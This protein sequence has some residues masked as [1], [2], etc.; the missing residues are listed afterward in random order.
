MLLLAKP[1]LPQRDLDVAADLAENGSDAA[2]KGNR[3]LGA[4]H[5]DD[6]PKVFCND[7][8]FAV[9]R[10]AAFH[11]SEYPHLRTPTTR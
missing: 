5:T 7:A 9:T 6:C 3:V 4:G 8:G 10:H 2:A 1:D 11:A